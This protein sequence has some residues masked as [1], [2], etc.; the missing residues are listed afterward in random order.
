LNSNTIKIAIAEGQTLV[1]EAFKCLLKTSHGLEIVGDA[2]DGLAAL[3]IAELA[4]P[5]VILLE[6]DLP[7]LDGIEVI[8][9]LRAEHKSVRPLVVTIHTELPRVI[10][11][12]RAGASGY[13]LKTDT[14]AQLHDGIRIAM[15]GECFVSPQVK[16]A[17]FAGAKGQ[18]VSDDPYF[19]LTQRERIVLQLA[20]EG[21][22]NRD[23]GK[24]LFISSRTVECHRASLMKKLHFRRHTDLVRFAVRRKVI[25]A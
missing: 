11:A 10:E 3:R 1:R 20:A 8:R 5:D 18:G 15:A 4:R 17:A 7:R 2:A 25:A 24:K 12:L 13:V 22:S 6:L 14:P 21:I 9:R 23:I 19:D 16:N